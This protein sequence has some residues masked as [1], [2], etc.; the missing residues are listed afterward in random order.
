MRTV[1][2]DQH[3]MVGA[4]RMVVDTLAPEL[5]PRSAR[6]IVAGRCRD[7]GVGAECAAAAAL[8]TSELVTNAVVHGRGQVSLGVQAGDRCVRVEVGDDEP[9]R[10]EVKALDRDAEGGR[11]ML[12]LDAM[13]SR[14]GVTGSGDGKLVWF[15]LPSHP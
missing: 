10:P 15:E 7:A 6:R 2:R 5:A 3:R 13:T 12:L 9:R 8:L 4:G 1:R 14:W 11:G